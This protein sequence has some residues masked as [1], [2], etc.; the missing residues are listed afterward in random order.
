MVLYSPQVE[1]SQQQNLS[2]INGF[3]GRHIGPTP[4]E[5][6]QMLNVLGISSLDELIDKTVPAAIR[7]SAPLQ[8]PEAQSEYAALAQ[9]KEISAKN[10]VFRSYIG[11]GYHDC[12]TPPVIGRNI[13]E[14]PGW[15]TAYTPYQA[16]IAQGRLEALLNFQT[17]IIDLTGL[18]I[19]NASLLDEGTA[20]AEAMAVSYG[21]CKN[22]GKAFFVAQDCHPQTIQVVQTRAKPLGI[23]V[24]VGDHQSF[25]FDRT[26]FGALLQYPATNGAIYDYTDFIRSAHKVGALVTVAADI[27]SLCLLTPPGE[28]GADIAVGST[29]RFG[30]PLGFGGPHAAYFATREEFKRQVP[31]RIVGVSKDANGKSALRLALQTREQHIRREKAT[32]NICTAQVLLAV[33][34]SM[35]AVYHGPSGLRDIAEKVW[36]LT[37]LLASGLTSFGYKIGSQPFFDT[38]RVE[39]GDKPLSELLA[40]AKIRQINLRVFD[41]ATVGIT[42]DETVTVEDV[43]ELWEIFSQNKDYVRAPGLSALNIPLDADA[44]NSYLTLPD[45]CDRTSSYLTHPVFNSHHS[46]TELLRYMHRL[47]AKDLSLN[48]SMIPL[49]SCTMKLNATAEM[50]PVSWPEFSK[51]HPFAPSHQTRGYQMMFVQLEQWLAEITGFAGISLQP[52]AGSQGEYAGLLVIRQYHESRGE[53]H[54]NICLIPQSAHGTNPASAVMAGMKVV[55][56]DCDSQGNIDVSDLHKK[57]EKHKNELAALMVTYPSTHGVFESE[58]KE[59]CEIV[60]NC[61]GQVYM[62][63]ANMNAQVGLCRP[64][65]FGADVCHL[66]LHKTFCIPHGGGGPGMGP[67]GVMSHLGEFLPSHSLLN[68]QQSTVNSQQSTVG[69]VSAAPWGSASILT[70][71]WMYIR[72]MGGVGLTEATKVAI[73]NANYMAKRLE[74]YYPVL[75]KGKS[76]LVA[77]ECILDLRLLKK[78]AGIEVEDIAKRLMDYGYH[79][80]TVSWPVAGTVMVEPTESESKQELD[81]FCDAMIAIRGEIAEIEKGNVDAQNNVLKNAPHTAES[82]MVDE[83]NCPYT[84]AEAAYPTAWTREH[85]FWPAVGRIDNAFGDRNFVCSCLPMEAYTQG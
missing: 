31:G 9:L 13:L 85:K 46:E 61:G 14:N 18:E 81:R 12:I 76:G 8:L 37:A 51:I 21:A 34:A 68:S 74:S 32:S 11:T 3:A 38:L 77:H 27:L 5:I 71:S 63:G 28:F 36:S 84:R 67:I 26:I 7:I 43:Q 60:H 50:L 35:Y 57:A 66:N 23:E 79:A 1:P 80:P 73:L 45:F 2:P 20:A 33:M 70:I 48:T 52:N 62:D 44:L 39:L 69:A 10:Q 29:Q 16:E 54:R 41:D 25:E 64:G 22:K 72:M 15:Y 59:I 83:W 82:L 47:E 17:M 56:V 78:T 58:I 75:Y 4:S 65:D 30:V 55:A 49:G 19:A 24:L 53:S 40:T 6:Q 42:L